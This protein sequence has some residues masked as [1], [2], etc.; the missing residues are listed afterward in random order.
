VYSSVYC[1]N[2]FILIQTPEIEFPLDVSIFA[3]CIG[4]HV[5]LWSD[6]REG[7]VPARCRKEV[8]WKISLLNLRDAAIRVRLEQNETIALPDAEHSR[9]LSVAFVKIRDS[10]HP[11]IVGIDVCGCSPTREA[12]CYILV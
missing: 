12:F 10:C 7:C 5:A 6:R 9:R 2:Y 3:L 4:I 1:A 11:Q 8:C